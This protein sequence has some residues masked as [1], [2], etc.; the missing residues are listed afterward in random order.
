MVLAMNMWIFAR[1]LVF[2][3]HDRETEQV[4]KDH[5]NPT[6]VTEELKSW[7]LASIGCHGTPR[8]SMMDSIDAML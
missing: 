6:Y 8:G 4:S 3:L 1:Y 7:P 5:M 2:F